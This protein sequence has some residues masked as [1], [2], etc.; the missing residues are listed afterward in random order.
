MRTNIRLKLSISTFKITYS[1][2][3]IVQLLTVVGLS[4]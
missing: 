1:Q 4:A 3:P 2:F